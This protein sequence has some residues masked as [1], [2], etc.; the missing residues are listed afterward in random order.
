MDDEINIHT[1]LNAGRLIEIVRL[2]RDAIQMVFEKKKLMVKVVPWVGAITTTGSGIGIERRGHL[3]WEE[4]DDTHNPGISI[5][6]EIKG[7]SGGLLDESPLR[8][9][10]KDTDRIIELEAR[11]T[12][13]AEILSYE[14]IRLSVEPNL[15]CQYWI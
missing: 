1:L 6:H 12:P 2:G 3:V 5:G 10:L 7:I 14:E 8:L 11:V 13:K 4:Y 15:I 9:D